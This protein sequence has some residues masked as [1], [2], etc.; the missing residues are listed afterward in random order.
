MNYLFISIILF[1]QLIAGIDTINSKDKG[2][3]LRKEED[4]IKVFSR[5]REGSNLKEIKV[6]CSLNTTV[7]GLVHVLSTKEEF[8]KWIYACSESVVL[9]EVSPM[10]TYH[11][12]VTDAPWP[13]EDRDL[14][15]HTKIAQNSTSG[16]VDIYGKG[17]VDYKPVNRN[18]VRVPN[19]E[20]HWI[21]TPK[22]KNTMDIVYLIA[23]DPGGSLPAWVV[24][25]GLSD[26][27]LK[28]MKSLVSLLPK[29]QNVKVPYIKEFE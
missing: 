29:Y 2:W 1:V 9:Q 18:K 15:V 3:K 20:A 28:T 21:I 24:N 7:S 8:P 23:V 5:D 22:N 16:V 27:P 11:Y 14:I 26:G 4:G 17:I 10:E 6:T 12:Q 13:V 25:L 19:Y